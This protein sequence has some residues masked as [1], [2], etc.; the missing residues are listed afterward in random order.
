[1]VW[2]NGEVI[3][4]VMVVLAFMTVGAGTLLNDSL[5]GRVSVSTVR[6]GQEQ[7]VNCKEDE[8]GDSSKEW[9]PRIRMLMRIMAVVMVIIS[10]FGFSAGCGDILW[11]MAVFV[12]VLMLATVIM[13]MFF[14]MVMLVITALSVLVPTMV[15]GISRKDRSDTNTTAGTKCDTMSGVV[16]TVS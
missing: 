8:E 13:L 15:Q 10:F 11:F 16:V 7:S 6:V 1:M 5:G 9:A 12:V 4:V 3:V 14:I 2:L